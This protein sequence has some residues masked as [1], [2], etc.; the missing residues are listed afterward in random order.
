MS[1]A[2]N[3]YARTARSALSPREAEAA[4]LIKAAQQLQVLKDDWTMDT[5]ALNKALNFNQKV[6][7]ILAT[8]ATEVDNPLPIEIKQNITNLSLFVFRRVIDT[9]IEPTAE[10]L[11]ALI[12]INHNL[13]AGLQ[14]R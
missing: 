10:K 9:M 7:T 2:A 14:G 1:F 8:A 5:A 6:W 13:A 3:A 4:V 12:A 11:S